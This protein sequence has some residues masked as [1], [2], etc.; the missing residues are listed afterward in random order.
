MAD[1]YSVKA[2][3]SAVDKNFTSTFKKAESVTDSL[4]QKIKSGLGFGVL[5]GIGQQAFSQLTQGITGMVGELNNSA[6]AW[7]TFEGNMKILNKSSSE[8]SSAKK[9][10]QDYA[11][12][13]IYNASEMA[14]TFAQLESVG[15]K[16]TRKLVKGF[17]GLAAAAENPKQ[18]MKT[19]SVQATQMAAR[20]TVAWQDFKLMLEQ[21]PAG[22]AAVAKEMGKTSAQLVSDIQ[23]G[24]V[25]TE[26]FFAAIEK[27]GNSEGFQKLATEYKTMDQ[28]MDGLQ[29]TLAV[30]L[31]PA[32][33]K[34]S[35]V[36]VSALSKLISKI[37]SV[38]ITPILAS[39]DAGVGWA[40][41]AF[42]KLSKKVMSAW[43]TFKNTGAVEAAKNALLSFNDA[44]GN[45]VNSV[46]QSGVVEDLAGFFGELAKQV[47]LVVKGISDFVA[48]LD[49]GLIG[50]FTKGIIALIGAYKG[51]KIISSVN[52]KLKVF[53]STVKSFFS[54]KPEL[55]LGDAVAEESN[56]IQ[57]H[58]SVV[59]D[60][61]K[62]LGN[63]FK[64]AFEGLGNVITSF[65]SAVSTLAQGIGTGL[66]TAFRGL[67]SALAMVPPTTW[68]SIAA[69]VL[70]VG[71][72][73]ALVGSQG[74]GL[75]AILVGVSGVI[76]QLPPVIVAVGQAI[77]EACQGIGDI[78]RSL[79]DAIGTVVTSISDGMA[80]VST[81]IGNA[82]S[83]VLN[84]L[85]G[86]IDAIGNAA[87]NAGNGF[88]QLANG[89]AKITKLNLFDMGAS[90]GTVATGLAGIGLASGGVSSASNA[91][92]GLVSSL[93][94]VQTLPPTIGNSFNSM[95]TKIT[96]SI[97]KINSGVKSGMSK[98]NSTVKSSL[99]SMYSTLNAARSRTYQCGVF[100]GQ[101]LAQGLRASEGQVRAAAASLANA[102]DA[103]I[104]A[105]ARIHSPSKV[106]TK[107]GR[108]IGMGLVNGL[109][110]M[111]RKV[112][113]VAYNL[114][115]CTDYGSMSS[116]SIPGGSLNSEYD[117]SSNSE[118]TVIVPVQLEG[119]TIAKVTAPYNEKEVKKQQK[120]SNRLKGVTA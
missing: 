105:K 22:M 8:I 104:R 71:G 67:G 95:A 65:G 111:Y 69:A 108:F 75:N 103:A 74:E 59:G 11:T 3:L 77:Q 68:L 38:D 83:G 35:G 118:Y 6:K 25:K 18:A 37:E 114:Y 102:A 31:G 15:T 92:R 99:N 40:S 100:I 30:K 79:G 33:D 86:I 73:F 84:S 1:S 50:A 43:H 58:T 93:K 94:V 26:D 89:I 80:T 70:A 9:E 81:A 36:G 55:G 7:K 57:K 14:S 120:I 49:P 56:K 42:E 29:E 19:L 54:K 21:S 44:V 64:S 61:L 72:A 62:D 52:S 41:K 85:A 76:Q 90:L 109:K 5:S 45:V 98:V 78:V 60:V 34:L 63:G 46:M 82:I 39:I 115:Q 112:Q 47:S 113:S 27:V 23:A 117:Y 2:I 116:F 107:D 10:M 119:K 53:N 88:N 13:T 96:A 106:T 12:K 24:T 32:F 17:G 97:S 101:G 110:D 91:L 48:K 66:A 16:N 28:A 87:L 20:P 4:S 51:L